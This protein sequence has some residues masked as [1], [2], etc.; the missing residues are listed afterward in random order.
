MDD[1][2]P[3]YVDNV[4]S[5]IQEALNTPMPDDLQPAIEKFKVDHKSQMD[6]L[7]ASLFAVM[8]F[9]LKEAA[10]RVDERAA[11]Q[12]SMHAFHSAGALY[13][14][15]VKAR[16]GEQL[17]PGR[18][19]LAAYHFAHW[20]SMTGAPPA[21]LLAADDLLDELRIPIEKERDALQLALHDIHVMA[22]DA[23]GTEAPGLADD[24][25]ERI[26]TARAS[27]EANQ[28]EGEA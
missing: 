27:I 3:T 24:V 17:L 2:G 10:L 28:S 20:A 11:I 9:W 21:N 25:L 12:I 5:C 8:L 7:V 22:L 6:H 14:A 15:Q 13:L 16:H 23:I 26:A 18:Y 19:A 4:L 1:R